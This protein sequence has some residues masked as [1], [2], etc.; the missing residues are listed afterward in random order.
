MAE[1]KA[2][3]A[4]MDL[5]S[6]NKRAAP[7]RETSALPG[8]DTAKS[9]S[10]AS[11]KAPAVAPAKG[12]DVAIIEE[13]QESL[14]ERVLSR[15]AAPEEAEA[16]DELTALHGVLTGLSQKTVIVVFALGKILAEV[17]AELPHGEFIPWVESNCSF[18][19]D[20]VNRYMRVYERYK[21]EPRR[22][23]AELSISEA[24]VEAGV[25]KLAAPEKDEADEI[26]AKGE[27]DLG[28]GMPKASEYRRIFE[29]ATISGVELKHHRVFPHTDGSLFVVRPETGPLKVCDLFMDMSIQDPSYQDAIQEVHHNVQM[30]LEVFYS[31]IEACETRGILSAPFDSSKPAMA[32]KMRNVTPEKATSKKKP[33]GQKAAKGRKK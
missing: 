33:T 2:S 22:A 6:G 31:K 7:A 32:R 17:K 23:L 13:K 14:L 15:K 27:A 29:Q 18:S 3:N 24:Y 25:K 26:R 9:A 10:P 4:I 19:Q 12:S 11:P 1:R 16:R 21:D 20:S 30:A 28:A 5:I 8:I